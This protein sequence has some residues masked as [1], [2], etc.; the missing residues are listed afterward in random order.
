MPTVRDLIGK[1]YFPREVTPPFETSSLA[2]QMSPH[3][4]RRSS[5]FPPK[6]VTA[7]LLIHNL[8]RPAG[9]RRRLA[10]PNPVVHIGLCREIIRN[11]KTINA[12]LSESPIAAS[13]P[14]SLVEDRAIEPRERL[15]NLPLLRARTRT[16][17]HVLLLADIA[18]FYP[19][20]YTH[21]IPWALHGKSVAK[22][23]RGP[24][25]L[26]NRIDTLMRAAQDGQTVGFPIDPI[27]RL[28]SRNSYS[29]P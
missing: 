3:L 10:I 25:F 8:A 23:N 2:G 15:R 28:F 16:G 20:A 14:A 21:S 17:P 27:R 1:G 12:K 7:K 19:S 4:S 29:R 9:V 22:A 24:S 5:D 26:G 18:R 13:R 6:G 11:W